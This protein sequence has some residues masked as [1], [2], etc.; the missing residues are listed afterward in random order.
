MVV[1]K[2]KTGIILLSSVRGIQQYLFSLFFQHDDPQ[3]KK[4]ASE[5]EHGAAVALHCGTPQGTDKQ[6]DSGNI[7][8]KATGKD[9]PRDMLYYS[10]TGIKEDVEPLQALESDNEAEPDSISLLDSDQQAGSEKITEADVQPT[11]SQI[12]KAVHQSTTSVN[13]ARERLEGLTEV[14]SLLRQEL[15]TIREPTTTAEG[16]LSYKTSCLH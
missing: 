14:V 13:S 1:N 10:S 8:G 6:K 12:L 7:T 2:G 9:A 16:S 11:P 5:T 4:A 15:Q 3:K